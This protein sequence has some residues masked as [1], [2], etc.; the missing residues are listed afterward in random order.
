MLRTLPLVGLLCG[1]FGASE[2]VQA[3][4][5]YEHKYGTD[6]YNYDVEG[7]GDDGYVH[8]NLDTD[9]KEVEGYIVK[10][11]G[12]EVYFEGE[13]TDYG[14]IEGYDEDGNYYELEVE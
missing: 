14:E 10:E 1:L 7:Y 6:Q 3:Q 13:F 4:H 2:A 5:K 11:N 9:E 12:E 8:G